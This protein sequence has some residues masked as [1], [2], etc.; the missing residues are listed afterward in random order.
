MANG[1]SETGWYVRANIFKY[2][3]VCADTFSLIKVFF[4][5][6]LSISF[7]TWVDFTSIGTCLFDLL[8]SSHNYLLFIKT[9]RLF[10]YCVISSRNINSFA[11]RFYYDY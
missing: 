11:E 9:H 5:S 6:V 7:I 4:A 3:N 10:L 2:A 8:I 1:N